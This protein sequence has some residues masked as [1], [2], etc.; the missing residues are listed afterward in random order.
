[1]SKEKNPISTPNHNT[2]NNEQAVCVL[3][4]LIKI[5]LDNIFKDGINAPSRNQWCVFS[6]F[7]CD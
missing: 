7:G 1:M 6:G 2:V 3:H 4:F 5:F